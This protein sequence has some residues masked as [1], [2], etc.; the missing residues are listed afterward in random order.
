[1][2]FLLKFSIEEIASGNTDWKLEIILFFDV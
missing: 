2:K 1:M